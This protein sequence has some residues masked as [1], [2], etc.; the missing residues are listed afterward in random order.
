MRLKSY[1]AASVEAA[2]HM[3]RTE[4]G[5]DA[6]LLDSRRAGPQAKHLGNYEVVFA[7]PE[8]NRSGPAQT[9]STTREKDHSRITTDLAD[10][11]RELDRMC[12]S[13]E[14]SSSLAA[15]AAGLLQDPEIARFY[16]ELTAADILPEIAQE[17]LVSSATARGSDSINRVSQDRMREAV[18]GQ[19]ASRLQIDTQLGLTRGRNAPSPV[20]CMVGPPGA[21]K[22]S[23]LVKL[24]IGKGLASRKPMLFVALDNLRVSGSEALSHY[25]S[26]IGATFLQADNARE[27]AHILTEYRGR[28]WIWIDTPGFGPK[29]TDA[30]AELAEITRNVEAVDT[31]LVLSAAMKSSDLKVAVERFASFGPRKLLFAHMDETDR[32]G[33][34]ISAM[35]TSGLPASFLANGQ[36]IPEAIEPAE[37][38]RLLTLLVDGNPASGYATYA[39][40][41]AAG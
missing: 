22:T 20:I 35:I 27:L 17:L 31:H 40:K 1:Y 29:E 36:Q 15:A 8:E 33:S 6:M 18:A 32:Y 11:R 4:L 26:L 19:I 5:E 2:M 39:G 24:A 37:C 21:G 10:L 34:I 14:R 12:N 7:L 28:Y 30:I 38:G 13:V 41:A 25:A 3:A 9:A 23:S 16:A